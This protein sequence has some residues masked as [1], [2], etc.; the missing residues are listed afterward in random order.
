MEEDD[1]DLPILLGTGLGLLWNS[2]GGGTGE[3]DGEKELLPVGNSANI[4]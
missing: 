1:L 4:R 3:S 2:T